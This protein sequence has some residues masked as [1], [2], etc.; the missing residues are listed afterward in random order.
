MCNPPS[1][2]TVTS[3][4][5]HYSHFTHDY[6]IKREQSL[7]FQCAIIGFIRLRQLIHTLWWIYLYHCKYKKKSF[8]DTPI[9]LGDT[10]IS[11]IAGLL[12]TTYIYF[13]PILKMASFA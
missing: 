2:R 9:R 6:S 11:R 13:S 8:Q 5:S 7:K 4:S 3:D 10:P 1:A 12:K